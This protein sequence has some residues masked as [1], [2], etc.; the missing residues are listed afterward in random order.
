L[1]GDGIVFPEIVFDDVD[2][3]GFWHTFL[4]SALYF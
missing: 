4:R 2:G 1:N 3:F